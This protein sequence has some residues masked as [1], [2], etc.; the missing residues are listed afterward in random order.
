MK[1]LEIGIGLTKE[2]FVGITFNKKLDSFALGY[3]DI[4][5]MC[6]QLKRY[7]NKMKHKATSEY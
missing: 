5:D 4:Q 2:G 7:A 1:E 6:K 3:D